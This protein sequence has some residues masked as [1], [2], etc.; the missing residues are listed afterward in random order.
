MSPTPLVPVILHVAENKSIW[1]GF[2]THRCLVFGIP[3]T[4][5]VPV[6]LV[7][8]CCSPALQNEGTLVLD[9]LLGILLPHG[10]QK[11]DL[12]EGQKLRFGVSCSYYTKTT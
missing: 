7:S 2:G 11:N 6:L 1:V 12:K 8:T 4:S 9:L 10:L 3:D 5:V